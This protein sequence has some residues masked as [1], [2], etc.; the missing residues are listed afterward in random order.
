MISE[1]LM[2]LKILMFVFSPEDVRSVFLR[3]IGI[4]LQVH[5]ALQPRRITA[6]I[7]NMTAV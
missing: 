5:M 2:A 7:S 1:V 6:P 4:C 3:S